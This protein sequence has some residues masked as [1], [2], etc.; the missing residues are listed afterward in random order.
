[1]KG[2]NIA[3]G[4]IDIQI[5]GGKKH[6]F[7]QSLNQDA[8]QDIYETCCEFGTPFMLPTIISSPLENILKA[9]E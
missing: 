5:N 1:M 9:I 8:L 3:P 7:S 4:F 6:Y 2:K